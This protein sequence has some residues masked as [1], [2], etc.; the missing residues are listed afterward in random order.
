MPTGTDPRKPIRTIYNVHQIARDAYL[1]EQRDPQMLLEAVA[2][3][4]RM[5]GRY[6][7]LWGDEL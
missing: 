6:R 2:N 3:I 4:M 7:D 5:T 1:D